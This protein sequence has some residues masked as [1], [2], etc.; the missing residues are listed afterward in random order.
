MEKAEELLING[1][2]LGLTDA[3]VASQ[4]PLSRAHLR[5][6]AIWERKGARKGGVSMAACSTAVFAPRI[7]WL[8]GCSHS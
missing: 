3:T 5:R 4:S 1:L 2:G 7:R 6:M 8:G